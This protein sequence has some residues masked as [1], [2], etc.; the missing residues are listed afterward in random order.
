MFPRQ[1]SLKKEKDFELVFKKGKNFDIDFLFL[2]LRRNDLK[3]N[4]FGFIIGKKISNKATAR[5]RIKRQLKGS[6]LKK[7]DEI[8]SGFDIIIG[9]RPEIANKKYKE[10]DETV[11]KIFK[12]AN[13]I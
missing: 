7:I 2:K 3:V 5:N 10:I 4:R 9:A 13:L 1:F 12:K 8:K 11:E 6:I